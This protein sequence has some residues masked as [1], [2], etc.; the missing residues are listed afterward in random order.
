MEESLNEY[1]DKTT[2]SPDE[3]DIV[4]YHGGCVDGFGSAFASYLYFKNSD[5]VNKN[6]NKVEYFLGSYDKPP[7]NVMNKNVLMC[8]FSYQY[9]VFVNMMKQAKNILILDHH[10]SAKNNL[11]KISDE[12][13][14]FIMSH[15]GAYITFKYFFRNKNVPKLIKYIED[16][17]LWTKKLE[18]I[19]EISGYIFS[20]SMIF[21]NYEN[22]MNMMENEEEFN[23]MKNIGTGM[24]LQSNIMIRNMMNSLNIYFTEI[25]N[26][27]YFVGH[28]NSSVLKS[29]IGNEIVKK[30]NNI[31]FASVFTVNNDD[32]Y[33]SLRSDNTRTDVNE[34]AVFYK[35]GG[36]RNASGLTVNT[37]KCI[38]NIYNTGK[39]Y[40]VSNMYNSLNHIYMKDLNGIKCVYLNYSKNMIQMGKYL[41]QS[42]FKE[43]GV[44]VQEC[45]SIMRNKN[46][47]KDYFKCDIACIYYNDDQDINVYYTI[48]YLD[49]NKEKVIELTK[50]ENEYTHIVSSNC[51]TFIGNKDEFFYKN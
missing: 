40:D 25:N 21:E 35:G 15:S 6:G 12:N 19:D 13:K 10:I 18:N 37:I 47:N 33:V 51:V 1:F 3:I 42:R 50:N 34:I 31:N 46:N 39:A 4:I 26:K 9:D 7:P 30:Y 23:K 14:V 8:D 29:D 20:I 44:E 48:V 16:R 27:Y 45:C 22:L 11:E 38:G 2:L 5:G 43:N 28:I 49:E 24:V 32:V 41:L 36:H 17:D